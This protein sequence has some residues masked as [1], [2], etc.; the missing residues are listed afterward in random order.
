MLAR[1]TSFVEPVAAPDRVVAD[2]DDDARRR[3]AAAGGRRRGSVFAEPV[4]ADASF[5]PRVISKTEAER[6]EI[7]AAVSGNILFSGLDPDQREM[8]IG[9]MERCSFVRG[10]TVLGEGDAS[11]QYMVI[12]SGSADVLVGGRCVLSLGPGQAFGEL[13]LMYDSPRSATIIA[14]KDLVSWAI[15]RQT[16]KQV[17][18]ATT[19]RVRWW[20]HDSLSYPSWTDLHC[21]H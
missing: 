5:R 19:M 12:A 17:V 2:D 7:R 13:A 8:L 6:D 20:C 10:A 9:A 16:F 4:Q 14:T 1:A 11:E 15:D 3:A 21:V 18:V